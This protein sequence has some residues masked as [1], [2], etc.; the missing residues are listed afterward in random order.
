M[1][2][3]LIMILVCGQMFIVAFHPH[4]VWTFLMSG[5]LWA[6][7]LIVA[8]GIESVLLASVSDDYYNE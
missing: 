2:W 4:E 3:A 7:W 6:R 5:P 8:W 1:R